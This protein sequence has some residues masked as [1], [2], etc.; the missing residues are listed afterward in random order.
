[1]AHGPEAAESVLV[2]L[3]KGGSR[4]TRAALSPKSRQALEWLIDE[5]GDLPDS[6]RNALEFLLK[7]LQNSGV[8]LNELFASTSQFSPTFDHSVKPEPVEGD[9]SGAAKKRFPPLSGSPEER[10][11]LLLE[12][13][14]DLAELEIQQNGEPRAVF[15][16][17]ERKLRDRSP[18][19]RPG[20]IAELQSLYEQLRL[21]Q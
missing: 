13:L 1:M 3:D 6:L 4:Q 9:A 8:D 14:D 5:K 7:K 16:E 12:N 10:L 21:R 20:E 11:K 18:D 2:F 19:L 15:K 17:A